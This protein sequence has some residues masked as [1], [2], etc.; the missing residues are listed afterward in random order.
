[1]YLYSQ[2]R[3]EMKQKR[4]KREPIKPFKLTSAK[5]KALISLLS[6]LQEKTLE[7]PYTQHN[8]IIVECC[9]YLLEMLEVKR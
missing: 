1:M 7:E 5:M 4:L 8:T 6:E 9:S 3:A 2:R